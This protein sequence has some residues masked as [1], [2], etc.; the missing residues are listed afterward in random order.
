MDIR[1]NNRK[2]LVHAGASGVGT[3][4]IQIAKL[5]ENNQIFC[6][7]GSS[8]KAA[9]CLE[10]GATTAINYKVIKLAFHVRN[11]LGRRFFCKNSCLYE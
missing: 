1:P 4:A 5:G 9:A 6:T 10:L 11:I 3:A 2:I 7:V 8:D